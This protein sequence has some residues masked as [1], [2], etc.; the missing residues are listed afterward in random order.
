MRSD[1][2][3]VVANSNR[4]SLSG[5]FEMHLVNC[6]SVPART[7]SI[8]HSAVLKRIENEIGNLTLRYSAVRKILLM[9]LNNVLET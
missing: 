4:Y 9:T 5:T 2:E 1:D 6:P 8:Y 7:N 3:A